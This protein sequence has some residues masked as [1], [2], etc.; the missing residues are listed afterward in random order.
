[1]A[2]DVMADV[3]QVNMTLVEQNGF[4]DAG[5]VAKEQLSEDEMLVGVFLSV[6]EALSSK[7]REHWIEAIDLERAKL[8]ANE[9]FGETLSEQEIRALRRRGIR[10]LPLAIILEVKRSGRYKCRCI[11]L[12]NLELRTNLESVW[13][14]VVS[15]AATRFAIAVGV[16]RGYHFCLFDL[17]TAYLNAVLEPG[18]VYVRLPSCWAETSND[19]RE[20]R[21]SL[22]GL[23]SSARN[24][25]K[26]IKMW[27]LSV[28]WESCDMAEGLFRR[29]VSGGYAILT[30]YV[31]DIVL[32]C[33]TAEICQ[34]LSREVLDRF[35]GQ[36]IEPK[37]VKV[38]GY[39]EDFLYWDVC[40]MD[41]HY[42]REQRK[43]LIN[44]S[45]YIRKQV[46]KW[47][48]DKIEGGKKVPNPVFDEAHFENST[49]MVCSGD[50][51]AK[52]WRALVGA[53]GWI[54][55]CC[56]PDIAVA[57]QC[58]AKWSEKAESLCSIP[59]KRAMVKVWKY[60]EATATLGISWSPE[61]EES[62]VGI[63]QP[64]MGGKELPFRTVFGDASFGSVFKT[65]RSASGV[66]LYWRGFLLLWKHV[67]QGVRTH[68]TAHS[69][70]VATSDAIIVSESSS[71]TSFY[72]AVPLKVVEPDSEGFVDPNPDEIIFTD[73]LSA[74]KIAQ[75][76]E[77]K[78]RNRH[79]LL[80]LH[81]V[82]DHAS[83]LVWI[84]TGAMKSDAL[85]KLDISPAQ[86][87]LLFHHVNNTKPKG[88][89]ESVSE[90]ESDKEVYMGFLSVGGETYRVS[91]DANVG[92]VSSGAASSSRVWK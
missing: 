79:F 12:G 73:N 7:E 51:V 17:T 31:D 71:F 80:R 42:A 50:A 52:G 47:G 21:R 59:M 14:P 91:F 27:L 28:G 76:A 56:R 61:E 16:S 26:L 1:M 34:E 25:W 24:W 37:T 20:L 5:R 57:V 33:P 13:A 78:D 87:R 49:R 85:T 70:L 44:S 43:C 92:Q 22:Y 83:K 11:V 82:R 67:V 69:E 54:V 81:R 41:F 53:L 4:P 63:Y 48:F 9:V 36:I 66:C 84:P 75:S 74:L 65:L 23:R 29:W 39:E 32:A 89:E 2:A 8:K 40:G 15:Q 60:L 35:P 62:F 19:V 45:A 6:A 18:S 77:V 64:M 58:L 38:D 46:K 3:A 68:S 88:L 90:E 55:A 10:V 72:D 30:L 86:R